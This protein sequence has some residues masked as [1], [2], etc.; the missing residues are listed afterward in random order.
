ML[1]EL[2]DKDLMSLVK[3]G[4]ASAFNELYNRYG[5]LVFNFAYKLT[6]TITEAEEVTQE[7][8]EK[9]WRKR[10]T[11]IIDKKITT[12]MLQICKNAAIDLLRRKKRTAP[13]DEYQLDFLVDD[14]INLDDEVEL[15]STR[16][17]LM[18]AI[19]NL[20]EEQKEIIKLIYFEGLTQREIAASLEIPLGTVK[21]RLKLAMSKL[22]NHFKR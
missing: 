1:D 18:E 17:T 14:T 5:R 8:F 2:S 6:G 13:I 4:D 21:S 9:I 16:K 3:E 12:W 22:K 7:V 11:Y 19:S 15:K 20:P 10:N